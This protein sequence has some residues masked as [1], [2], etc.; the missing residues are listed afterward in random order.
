MDRF[1]LQV[2]DMQRGTAFWRDLH[3]KI[4]EGTTCI[5]TRDLKNKIPARA[6][7]ESHPHYEPEL[8]I[9]SLPHSSYHLLTLPLQPAG[10]TTAA[11]NP[12]G[13]SLFGQKAPVRK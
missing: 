13:Q 6:R 4:I 11:P 3:D 7:V 12:P 5:L 10:Q 8:W 2:V 9:E 1:F